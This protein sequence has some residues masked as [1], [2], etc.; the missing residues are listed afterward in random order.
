MYCIAAV[1]AALHMASEHR[2]HE[3]QSQ[4]I[5]SGPGLWHHR[6]AQCLEPCPALLW[7]DS[8]PQ[9]QGGM[10]VGVLCVRLAEAEPAS[11][12]HALH[13]CEAGGVAG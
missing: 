4:V 10:R 3:V 9:Q 1:H 12:S 2:T 7:C 8:A 11:P 13:R 6:L 5:V